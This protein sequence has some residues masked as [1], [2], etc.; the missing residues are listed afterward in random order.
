MLVL[1]RIICLVG[2]YFFG[3]I[4][5]SYI[6]GKLHGID[7]REYGSG[8]AGTTNAL[9]VLG[10]K[11]GAVVFLGDL[12]KSVIACS[13]THIIMN[14]LGIENVYLFVI[15]TAAGV[16]LG[17]NFPFYMQFKGGKGIAAT[18]GIAIGLLDWRV[19][20][21]EL[22]LFVFCVVVTKY[23]SVGSI[24]LVLGLLVSYTI[25]A[26]TGSYG[27]TS[28]SMKLESCI[29]LG[30]I[31][32]LAIYRHKQNIVRL[33]KGTENKFSLKG[34]NKT[35]EE[36]A[37]YVKLYRPQSYKDGEV[38][39]MIIGILGAGSWGSAL[40]NL[41]A[42]NGHDVTVWSIDEKEIEMLN[43][44]RE[45]RDRLPGVH[46]NETITFTTDLEQTIKGKK[47]IVC[48]V[49][50]PFIRSTAKKIAPYITNDQLIVNVSKGIEEAT[51]TP[52]V[53]II[54]SEIP[55]AK[56]AVLSGPSHA[57]EV[58]I[59]IPTT[60]VAG[61]RDMDTA[62]L[63]QNTFMNDV[64]RVYTSTDVTGIELGGS[65]KNV[66]ALAAGITDGLG[67][68]DN[69]KAALMTRGMAEILRLGTA[70]GA[71]V[72]TLA[73]LSGMGDLIVTCTSKH[74]RNRNAGYLIGQGKSYKE[75]MA[76]VKMVVEGVY[77]AKAT[78]KLAK[79]YGVDM[80]IVEEVNKVLFEGKPARE[81]VVD[82]LTRDRK[83]EISVEE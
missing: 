27:F 47:M 30:L 57:E 43:T 10:K 60:V 69:T 78:L 1:A 59:G 58:G 65:V 26:Y 56:V 55:G 25:F 14:A 62:K 7:I 4:Q 22:G 53:E 48:A 17:H 61:A 16:V 32:L 73:G 18:S 23:V 8:N 13:V 5:T 39:S 37:Q 81:A 77:S 36:Q 29:V 45:Q 31:T 71:H 74:S 63:I 54:E 50:S 19:A 24:C 41:L 75:A 42:G 6:Y 82:L 72:E 34:R 40:A 68:G 33:I 76:E 49:P 64:F 51:L 70:M 38:F 28:D 9:R 67:F 83:A 15:Y 12:F 80:P 66:I 46:L 52:I 79:K 21:I 11:A 3:I 35:T 2:G 20:L 44:Y